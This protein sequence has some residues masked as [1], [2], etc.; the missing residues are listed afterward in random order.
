MNGAKEL[1]QTLEERKN[2]SGVLSM[3]T[4]F[5]SKTEDSY[6]VVN[7][8]PAPEVTRAKKER[9][10]TMTT[11]QIETIRQKVMQ[12]PDKV[13]NTKIYQYWINAYGHL[14]RARLVYLD[15]MAML[16]A[17]TVEDLG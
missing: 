2:A 7:T 9:S 15:T 1:A 6:Q 10:R 5:C 8:P 17:E 16:D 4:G 12:T 14:V 3:C 11:K 13:Y